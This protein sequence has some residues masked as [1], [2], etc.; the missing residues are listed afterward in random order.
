MNGRLFQRHQQQPAQPPEFNSFDALF[1]AFLPSKLPPRSSS[2]VHNL[3]SNYYFLLASPL[4]KQF[5]VKAPQCCRCATSHT[6]SQK[7]RCAMW[8]NVAQGGGWKRGRTKDASRELEVD[9]KTRQPLLCRAFLRRRLMERCLRASTLF[10]GW[11]MRACRGL[12]E[13]KA[14]GADLGRGLNQASRVQQIECIAS[15]R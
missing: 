10:G 6:D 11:P 13:G 9:R 7:E 14:Q 2:C 15:A 12:H 3:N 1:S 8:R 5:T 4:H